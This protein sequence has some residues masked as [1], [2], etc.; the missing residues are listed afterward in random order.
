MLDDQNK[1]AQIDSDNALAVAAGQFKQLTYT[2]FDTSQLRIE[3]IDNVVLAGM[4]GSALA[5]LVCRNWW[6]DQLPVPFTITR[7][8][9]V[10][11]FVGKHTLVIISSYSGNTEETA[12]A[13][14]DAAD[15]GAHIVCVASG[16]E[17]ERV[18]EQENYPFLRLPTGYQPRMA[19]WFAVRVLAAVFEEC[20]LVK[21]AVKEL[22]QAPPALQAAA[23][24]LAPPVA[25]QD[26]RAKQI[27]VQIAGT[28]PVI[29]GGPALAAA[30]YKWKISCNESAKNL[31]WSNEFP[32]FN[33]NEFM[34]WT[35]HP[36]S[37]PFTV[38]EL[39]SDL[40]QERIQRRFNVSNRLLSG[41]MPQPIEVTAAGDSHIEQLLWAIQ[42]GDFVSLYLAVLNNQNPTPVDLVEKLKQELA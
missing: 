37:K 38:V 12:S 20:G 28:T 36:V 27:A 7:G 11:A 32:E 3:Q 34:G 17:L 42:L 30:A 35:S 1:I 26:N 19:V 18:A 25:T 6:D 2:D 9:R 24:Q 22:E 14:R 8:Y 41:K 16:G 13:L 33:H 40:D 5:G 23:E 39:Q 29:Y 10:P 4:G 21:G 15:K 31:A